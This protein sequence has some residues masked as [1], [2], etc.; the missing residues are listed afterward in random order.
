MVTE[1]ISYTYDAFGKERNPDEA[2]ENP[3]RY[4]GEYWDVETGTYYLRARYYD[5]AIGRFTQA[6]T[7]WNTS[8]MIYGDNPQKINERED[9]LGLK[10]YSYAPQ[11]S[12]IIQVGNLYVYCGSNPVFYTDISGNFWDIVFDLIS[13]GISIADVIANPDDPWA[14]AGLAGDTVDVIIPFVSGLGEG[15]KAVRVTDKAIDA[16]DCVIDAAKASD[17]VI[18]AAKA[19]DVVTNLRKFTK[20]NFRV[21]LQRLTKQTGI[22]MEAHHVLPQKFFDQFYAVDIDIHNPIFGAWVDVKQHHIWSYA[23]NQDWK[24]FFLQ[25]ENYTADQVLDFARELAEKYGFE[26]LF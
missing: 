21:N 15:I 2:D 1:T 4:C 7:H 19:S 11:I 18:D 8:N 14:W 16:A 13:C 3:F 23:Y 24:N 17:V 12:A 9:R 5:P 22:G 26:L 20:E 25:N 10:S 6:D